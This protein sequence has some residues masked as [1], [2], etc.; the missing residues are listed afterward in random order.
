MPLPAFQLDFGRW[1][2]ELKLQNGHVLRF[3]EIYTKHDANLIE[4]VLNWDFRREHSAEVLFRVDAHGRPVFNGGD[5]Q[6]G[7]LHL[8]LPNDLTY[9]EGDPRL[10]G[11]SLSHFTMVDMIHLIGLHLEGGEMP[12]L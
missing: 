9:E 3:R 1:E 10:R 2:G 8:D 12:W 11:F 4:R 5:Q 6:N 7:R